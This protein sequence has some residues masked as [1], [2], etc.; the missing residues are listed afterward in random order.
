MKRFPRWF[1]AYCSETTI[2]FLITILICLVWSCLKSTDS[3]TDS[4]T[5][6][7]D[8]LKRFPRWFWAYCS[9]TSIAFLIT[10]LICL[11]WSCLRSTDSCTDSCTMQHDDLKRFP[12]W[13]WAYC[14]ETTI[15]FLITILI[16]LADS[17]TDSCTVHHDDLKRFP[18]W[19]WAY[20]SE[21]TI[22]FLI[23]ILVGLFV[24]L[25]ACFSWFSVYRILWISQTAVLCTEKSNA[26]N[27]LFPS[28]S[29]SFA[30][31][32][33]A[34]MHCPSFQR[35]KSPCHGMSQ[36]CNQGLIVV[37]SQTLTRSLK[38]TIW[39]P[40]KVVSF[41]LCPSILGMKLSQIHFPGVFLECM[42]SPRSNGF[43]QSL[44]LFFPVA[45][46]PM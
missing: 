12:R 9:E 41:Q 25:C 44:P 45:P 36:G 40:G 28:S 1:W 24:N 46:G 37:H 11:A 22:A 21:T 8:D 43:Y 13:F 10:I 32:S 2:A 7:H 4:C 17:C 38:M 19:F 14:S 15:A 39:N 26:I 23:A 31:W 20:C 35:S 6:Q 5:L 3:C 16:C 34:I 30:Q 29:L 33:A 42:C 27:H 18:R